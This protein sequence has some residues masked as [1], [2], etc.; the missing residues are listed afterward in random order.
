MSPGCCCPPTTPFSSAVLGPQSLRRP[1][2]SGET[3]TV[4]NLCPDPDFFV[5]WLLQAEDRP[6]TRSFL[7]AALKR[8]CG[9]KADEATDVLERARSSE[10]EPIH[11]YAF[12]VPKQ[13]YDTHIYSYRS[14]LPDERES[15][16]ADISAE[17]GLVTSI[18]QNGIGRVAEKYVRALLRRAQTQSRLYSWVTPKTTL[19]N[20]K[21]LG[22]KLD[23]AAQFSHTDTTISLGLE[24]KNR[25]ET[26]YPHGKGTAEILGTLLK[27]C[28]RAKVQPVLICAHMA[29]QLEDFCRIAGIATLNLNRQMLPMNTKKQATE[30]R[31]I[32]GDLGYEFIDP[33]RPIRDGRLS[34]TIQADLEQIM[35]SSWILD[36][37]HR[38]TAASSTAG[39]FVTNMA[40]AELAYTSSSAEM[41]ERVKVRARA[42]TRALSA[43][44]HRLQG[45]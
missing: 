18:L 15:L 25:G 29:S 17:L 33:K 21:R 6:C 40:A 10:D 32:R 8:G 44:R 24:V 36:A 3:V 23:L 5:R 45:T 12:K 34:P 14:L 1:Q 20:D 42:R 13:T 22:V 26:Y 16:R 39:E 38:W 9:I 30:L 43:Y 35:D 27:A 19:G 28:L 11:F 31:R 4:V 41:P 7:E 2:Q 37:R